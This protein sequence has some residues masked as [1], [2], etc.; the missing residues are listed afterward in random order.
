M[1]GLFPIL[2]T[3]KKY[4]LE[5]F[6]SDVIAGLI[7]GI[8][9]EYGLYAAIFPQI[10][11]ALLGTSRQLGVGPVAMDSLLIATGISTI[12]IVGSDEY[13]AIAILLGLLVGVIQI[14]LG[15]LRLGFLTNF[16]SQPVISGFTSAVAIMIGINQFKYLFDLEIENSKFFTN[17]VVDLLSNLGE[18]HYPTLIVG[19]IG[20]LFLF[21]TKWVKSRIPFSLIMIAVGI[22]VSSVL[23]F[24]TLGIRVVGVI[25]NGIPKV[26]LPSFDYSTLR[27][28]LPVAGTLAIVGFLEAFS[29]SKQVQL[30]HSKEYELNANKEL[31]ALGMSNIFGAFFSGFPVSGSFS[32]T[33]INDKSGAKTTVALLV[34]SCVVLIAIFF[35]T[36]W[37]YYLPKVLLAVLIIV[38][39]FGLIDFKEFR[40]LWKLDRY[41]FLMMLAAFTSTLILGL[42]LGIL[43]GVVISLGVLIYKT[44]NPHIAILGRVKGTSFYKNVDRYDSVDVEPEIG[45]MRFDS[46]LYFANVSA[47]HERINQLL[48]DKPSIKTFI[49]DGQ[50]ISDVDST[51]IKFLIDINTAFNEKGMTFK[52]VSLIGPVRD[53]LF[54]AGIV[55]EI[56]LDNFSGSIATALNS[57]DK[58]IQLPFQTNN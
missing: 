31:L 17:V 9:P 24:D 58:A 23:S 33:A 47:L 32:R 3:L 37:F 16:L 14:S 35:L 38:S 43:I 20:L 57:E 40:T 10:V 50:S 18:V 25:P 6:K 2:T 48:I 27:E 42:E 53:K 11:Y 54:K 15:I 44:S 13:I 49:L 55:K 21:L 1:Q 39:V 51:G 45:I 5:A 36:D 7:V 46:R 28:L 34:S 4:N 19:M 8:I 41:D 30:K 52:I 12:A 22:L 26:A 56:G 29:I